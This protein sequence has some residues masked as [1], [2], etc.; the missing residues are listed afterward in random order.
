MIPIL[1]RM[2]FDPSTHKTKEQC[3]SFIEKGK[4]R[5]LPDCTH[6]LAGQTV[7]LPE[8]EWPDDYGPES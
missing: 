1:V 7:D 3:H 4:I 6:S 2:S 5:F 8:N